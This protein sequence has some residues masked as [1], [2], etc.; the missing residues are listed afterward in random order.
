MNPRGVASPLIPEWKHLDAFFY[1]IFSC[2]NNRG[3]FLPAEWNNEGGREGF[4]AAALAAVVNQRPF[5]PH[6]WH[7]LHLVSSFSFFPSPPPASDPSRQ[8]TLDKQQETKALISPLNLV[9]TRCRFDC[10]NKCERGHKREQDERAARRRREAAALSDCVQQALGWCCSCDL[11]KGDGWAASE[12]LSGGTRRFSG[13]QIRLN[14]CRIPLCF[15][16]RELC[17]VTPSDTYFAFKVCQF[18]RFPL[19]KVYKSVSSAFLVL[20]FDFR[21][22]FMKH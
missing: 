5:Q 15:R 19:L 17:Q 13:G 20:D 9:E 14:N 7:T 21:C 11:I 10:E 12:L 1:F 22:I 6:F 2:H 8:T 18:A 16:R 3:V 4:S